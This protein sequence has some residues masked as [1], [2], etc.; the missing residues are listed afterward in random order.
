MPGIGGHGGSWSCPMAA[1]GLCP[2]ER[3][4]G[5]GGEVGR[6]ARSGAIPL[7]PGLGLAVSLGQTVAAPTKSLSPTFLSPHPCQPCFQPPTPALECLDLT[8][9]V[10]SLFL[11]PAWSPHRTPA[12]PPHQAALRIEGGSAWKS[13]ST[14]PATF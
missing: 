14:W 1:H 10:K 3:L 9:F 4:V 2:K 7:A 13:L 8:C 5:D 6:P 11:S 12:R